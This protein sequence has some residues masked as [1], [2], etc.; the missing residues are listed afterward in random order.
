MFRNKF[1]K[2][3]TAAAFA[4][5]GIGSFNAM[6]QA[7]TVQAS[8]F[9][10]LRRNHKLV[11]LGFGE[12]LP[13]RLYKNGKHIYAYDDPTDSNN[14][15]DDSINT[16]NLLKTHG[17]KYINGTKYYKLYNYFIDGTSAYVP[18]KYFTKKY[19]DLS[20]LSIYNVN[21]KIKAL[22]DDMQNSD[23]GDWYGKGAVIMVNN[24]SLW[25][26]DKYVDTMSPMQD[27][28]HN[29]DGAFTYTKAVIGGE[30]KPEEFK[31]YCSKASANTKYVIGDDN[32]D[33]Y[34]NASLARGG[35]YLGGK[36]YKIYSR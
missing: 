3:L 6:S 33:Y 20:Y 19:N 14:F 32:K 35:V 34:T 31:K 27:G 13:L 22:S 1:I 23:D 16:S 2:L 15:T 36:F 7:S 30:L 21:H 5:V 25:N 28:K 9:H 10:Y 29:A 11:T 4:V 26:H 17:W 24:Y 12:K 18:A 8:A